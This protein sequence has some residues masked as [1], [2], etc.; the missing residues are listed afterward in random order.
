[1][2]HPLNLQGSTGP[3]GPQGDPGTANVIYSDW[4][5]LNWNLTDASTDK[6]MLISLDGLDISYSLIK[7]ECV[8]L[9]YLSQWG[10][11][12]IYPLNNAGRWNN[13]EYT[14]TFGS[15]GSTT[16]GLII[17]LESTDGAALTE[18]QYAAFRG[19]QVRY[20]IIPGGVHARSTSPAPDYSD[21]QAVCRY[22]GIQ[23]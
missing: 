11:S 12:S 8:V 17:T 4:I 15:T 18:Y 10:T 9:V 21:Y 3:Q 16:R 14:Y 19:N 22:Y 6:K 23:E 20:V 13:T 1:M 5:G 7:S 2:G